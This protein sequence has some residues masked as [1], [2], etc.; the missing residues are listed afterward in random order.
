MNFETF[1]TIEEDAEGLS[2]KVRPTTYIKQLHPHQAIVELE[3]YIDS[4]H[5]A[6]FPYGDALF[7]QGLDESEGL[8]KMRGLVFELETC[9]GYLDHLK[10]HY[11]TVH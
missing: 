8:K 4:L 3:T 10:E 11:Q 7:E 6:L 1:F 9:Q 2:V 5:D